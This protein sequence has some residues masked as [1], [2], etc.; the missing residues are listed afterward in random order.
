MYYQHYLLDNDVSG[1]LA[2]DLLAILSHH[3]NNK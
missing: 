3:D 1:E 2:C